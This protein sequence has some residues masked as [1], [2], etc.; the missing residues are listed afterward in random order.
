MLT[1]AVRH[2]GDG[3]P[4]PVACPMNGLF[5]RLFFLYKLASGLSLGGVCFGAVSDTQ[6]R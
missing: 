4:L 6:L 3:I 2:L 1:A 5:R